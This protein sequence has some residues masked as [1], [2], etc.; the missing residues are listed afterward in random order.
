MNELVR[1]KGMIGF[2]VFIIGLS[3]FNVFKINNEMKVDKNN[4]NLI[5]LNDN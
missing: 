5:V 4:S 2:A 3:V 1:S